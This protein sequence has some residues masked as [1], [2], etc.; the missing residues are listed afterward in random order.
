MAKRR[1][2]RS[3]TL[4]VPTTKDF[5]SVAKILQT[6]CA[7]G[8]LVRDFARH[9]STQNPRFDAERFVTAASCKR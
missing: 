7:S 8:S 2:K 5:V 9:F 6:H 3:T 1:K 4:G